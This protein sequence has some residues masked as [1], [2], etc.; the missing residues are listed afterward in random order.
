VAAS[1]STRQGVSVAAH[2]RLRRHVLLGV[3]I[4]GGLIG[5]IGAIITL[6]DGAI[7]LKVIGLFAPDVLIGI[8]TVWQLV[9]LDR[10]E[11]AVRTY[12]AYLVLNYAFFAL[13][14]GGYEVFTTPWVIM[15]PIFGFYLGGRRLGAAL[16][17]AMLGEGLVAVVVHVTGIG[18]HL[19][20][21]PPS[22]DAGAQVMVALG[23][24]ELFCVVY[25]FER[26]RDRMRLELD[27]ALAD[28]DSQAQTIVALIESTSDVIILVDDGQ[29]VVLHNR[30]ASETL[31]RIATGA[32]LADLL[33]SEVHEAWS[34]WLDACGR[35]GH[36]RAEH[37]IAGRVFELSL[38]RVTVVDRIIGFTLIARDIT[39]RREAEAAL[40]KVRGQL[41]EASRRSGIAESAAAL[42]HGVG[43]ALNGAMVS[44][45]VV[46]DHASSLRVE[47]FVRA[48]GEIERGALER[49]DDRAGKLRAY[50]RGLSDHL[51]ERKATLLGEARLL[52]ASIESV[53]AALSTQQQTAGTRQTLDDVSLDE[54]VLSAL[55]A[56]DCQVSRSLAP[57]GTIVTD[58]QRL[59]E[60]VAN[61][62]SVCRGDGMRV[63]LRPAGDGVELSISP[64]Q[65]TVLGDGIFAHGRPLHAAALAA[66]ALGGSLRCDSAIERESFVLELPRDRAIRDHDGSAGSDQV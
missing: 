26:R 42:L 13:H 37:A 35:E 58:R 39:A 3:A 50:L 33:A 64:A 43:N 41:L 48:V 22:D 31:P 2:D 12:A 51:S 61:L 59:I 30:A 53:A 6:E 63:V 16:T 9:G 8:V 56:D 54:I 60:I 55:T 38:S 23:I 14:A 28:L 66:S 10:L 65:R 21:L 57:T 7:D 27:G 49:S 4:V 18:H 32:S 44:S 11:T 1:I 34:G 40:R 46:A 17:A 45:A 36:A 25:L 62:F 5:A 29:R 19:V 15:P 24:A 52:R 47:G 20:V